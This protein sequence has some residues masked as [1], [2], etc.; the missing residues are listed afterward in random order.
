MQYFGVG[1][2]FCAGKDTVAEYLQNE[3][4]CILD[5][6]S[7]RL[8]ALIKDEM[9]VVSGESDDS[10]LIPPQF[11]WFKE[12]LKSDPLHSGMVTR[13]AQGKF[14][15][16]LRDQ[17]GSDALAQF[18]VKRLKQ[19]SIKKAAITAIRT[20][21][22]VQFFRQHLPNFKMIFVDADPEVRY[23]RAVARGTEKD[24]VD[25]AEFMRVEKK[26]T[27]GDNTHMNHN[28]VRQASDYVI[29][30][31]KGLDELHK[32]IDEIVQP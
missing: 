19:E 31:D 6:C 3:Y 28:L 26:E 20:P 32:K 10:I 15:D 25:K 5:S 27:T 18:I 12:H 7:D 21:E 11:D 13:D 17:F 24:K 8:R 30:N 16:C 14:A 2:L 29:M 23:E 22:E 4:D 1:G 9:L